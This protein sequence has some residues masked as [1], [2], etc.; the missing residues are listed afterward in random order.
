MNKTFTFLAVAAL[1]SGSNLALAQSLKS[2]FADTFAE[3]QA[4]SSNSSQW[5]PTQPSAGREA[6]A[7]R[8]RLTLRD[9]QALSSNSSQWQFDQGQVGV[10][11]GPTFAKT[12]PNGIPF[13]DY[14]ALAANSD[15]YATSNNVTTSLIATAEAAGIARSRG[16]TLR[17]RLTSFFHRGTQVMTQDD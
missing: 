13:G 8:N 3:M 5:K 9:Y 2:S 1:V 16:P 14:Q 6:V 17:D 11:N 10:D 7:P 15:Q 4:L 12:H